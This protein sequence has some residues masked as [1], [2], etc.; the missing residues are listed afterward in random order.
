[1]TETVQTVSA[2]NSRFDLKPISR[3]LSGQVQFLTKFR[4]DSCRLAAGKADR[5]S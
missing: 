2:Y 4:V 5:F 3:F 1:M